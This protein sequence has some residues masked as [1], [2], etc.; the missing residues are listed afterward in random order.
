MATILNFKKV[1]VS[2]ATKDEA[3]AKAP[4][5]TIMKNATQAYKNWVEKQTEGITEAAKKDW[6][7][8]Y[9]EKESKNAPGV[10]FYIVDRA[11]VVDTRERPYKYE[12]IKREGT[13]KNLTTYVFVD[14]ATGVEVYKKTSTPE[15]RATKAEAI[16]EM[17]EFIAGGGFKG[18]ATLYS[19]KEEAVPT[20]LGKITYTPSKA[21]HMGTYTVFGIEA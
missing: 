17:K 1:E 9:I 21:S 6:M 7:L 19:R 11:A 12:N 2:G 16:Q 15:K 10:G 18:T 3:L 14:D 4:F 5:N 20:P 13:T 8:S